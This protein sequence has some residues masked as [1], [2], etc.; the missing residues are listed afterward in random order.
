M[1]F[2]LDTKQC[3][4]VKS[5]CGHVYEFESFVP[6]SGPEQLL[7]DG[8]SAKGSLG[9]EEIDLKSRL[10]RGVQYLSSSD[11]QNGGWNKFPKVI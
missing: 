9:R 8:R 5:T 7:Q 10:S 6:Y 2:G 1:S 11:A 3:E 4:S